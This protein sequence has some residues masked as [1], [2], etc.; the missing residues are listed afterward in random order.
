[1][2]KE[3]N[4]RTFTVWHAPQGKERPRVVYGRAY[5]PTK[6]REAEEAIQWAYRTQVHEPPYEARVPLNVWVQAVFTVP[7]SDSRAAKADKLEG[8]VR[9]C[10][11]PDADNIAKLILDALNGLAWYDDAQITG[12]SVTKRYGETECM[13]V[14]MWTVDE[15]EE[16]SNDTV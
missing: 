11:K 12:L 9:P 2:R 3:E 6:T 8:R 10:R 13:R 14:S 15:S 16:E 7:K 4:V 1:M 5:T